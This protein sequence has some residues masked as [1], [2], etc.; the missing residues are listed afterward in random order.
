M[1]A[2]QAI[3]KHQNTI[4]TAERW[5]NSLIGG[6]AALP[7]ACGRKLYIETSVKQKLALLNG[8]D[9]FIAY[10]A[11]QEL[12]AIQ[13]PLDG[14]Q[15]K[16]DPVFSK[17]KL[18]NGATNN[19][20][21]KYTVT[22]DKVIITGISYSGLI[23]PKA[24]PSHE[25]NAMYRVKK[26]NEI[27]YDNKTSRV[28][29]ALLPG[30][31]SPSGGVVSEVKTRHAA[32][33]GQS[34]DLVKASWLMGVHSSTAYKEDKVKEY[35]L[36]HNPTQ[37]GLLDTYESTRDKIGITTP[38]A[39]HLAAVLLDIQHKG[40][41]VKWVAHSQGAAIFMSAVKYHNQTTGSSLSLNFVALHAGA[42][43]RNTDKALAKAG[44]KITDVDRNN[45]FD[46]VPNLTG[47]ERLTYDKFK[48]SCQFGAL[49]ISK[50]NP[51]IASS[52]HTLPFLGLES[53]KRQLTIA[54]Q[55][56]KAAIV[57]KEIDNLRQHN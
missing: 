4:G 37:S 46:L 38:L 44:I 30:A 23:G 45:P 56:R 47:A 54:G 50:R 14:L 1:L 13:K 53:Y 16:H 26:T 32:V 33:N 20:A 57:Q 39:K 42:H 18:S 11:I 10:S 9:K 48:K 2:R 31:W 25:R 22:S 36:F 40:T 6:T 34:S 12:A 15:C 28:D 24:K 52:P 55:H 17:A 19:F 29:L 5:I 41:P 7:S 49:V 43:N 35:T 51:T 3:T 27:D 8:Y 21:I